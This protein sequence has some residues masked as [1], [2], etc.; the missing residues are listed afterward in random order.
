MV[1]N[2]LRITKHSD[3]ISSFEKI[4]FFE[5]AL[6]CKRSTRASGILSA[7]G[8]KLKGVPMHLFIPKEIKG[9]LSAAT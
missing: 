9:N 4:G 2:A 5:H 8:P 3:D 6:V 7:I 1:E